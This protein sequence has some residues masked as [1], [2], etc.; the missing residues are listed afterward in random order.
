M[1]ARARGVVAY[2]LLLAAAAIFP[3]ECCRE[4]ELDLDMAIA[5]MLEHIPWNQEP[6]DD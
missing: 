2:W 4:C 5:G 1:I 6:H 3:R